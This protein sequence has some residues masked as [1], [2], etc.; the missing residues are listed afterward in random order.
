M[1]PLTTR[2]G[3]AE[4]IPMFEPPFQ[5]LLLETKGDDIAM[6][7]LPATYRNNSHMVRRVK[8]DVRSFLCHDLDVKRL[9]DVHKYLWLVGLPGHP[10][11]LHYQQLKKRSIVVAEQTDLHLVW[12]PNRIFIKPLSRY[13]LS[14]RFW[15]QQLCIDRDLYS[16]ALGFLLSYVALIEREVDFHLAKTLDLL[17]ADITWDGWLGLVEEIL[18]TTSRVPYM[19]DPTHASKLPFSSLEPQVAVNP[20]FNYGELRLGRLNWIYRLAKGTPRG[21]FS[22]C[23][24]YGAFMR[25]NVNSLIT[26]FA[27]TTIVLSAMQVGLSTKFLGS[28]Y[29]FG[30]ASYVFSVFAILAPISALAAIFTILSILFSVNLARTLHIRRSRRAHGAGV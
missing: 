1:A 4:K 27:Y 9:T 30:M 6:P 2:N 26:L 19:T 17:P 20:R 10:R 22:N 25:D 21:Y 29:A 8:D 16:T 15:E 12:S 7:V 18:S 24:T 28:S 23:T 3:V 14:P 5:T 11:P 13:F